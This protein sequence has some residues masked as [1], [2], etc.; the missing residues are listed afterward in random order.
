MDKN[1]FLHY[2]GTLPDIPSINPAQF[3]SFAVAATVLEHDGELH[4]LF[5]KRSEHVPQ[6]GEIS[7][8]G[9]R[10]QSGIDADYRDTAIR[11]T[12]EELLIRTEQITIYG[13]LDIQFSLMNNVI[14][15]Y[16]AFLDIDDVAELQFDTAEVAS[17]FTVPISYFINTQ[18]QR[19]QVRFSISPTY[20]DDTGET[21]V[22]LPADK[23]GLPSLYSQPWGN[24]NVAV[25]VY[26]YDGIPIW[27]LTERIVYNVLR[28]FHQTNNVDE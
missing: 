12:R 25:F 7:F 11:E 13:A 18:P 22:G 10:F 21:V 28:V 6:P 26:M 14:Y 1:Q 24:K 4:F 27:G 9:G 16:L 17:L 15:P 19:Y 3:K 5:E 2:A 20:I 23:I 8:P